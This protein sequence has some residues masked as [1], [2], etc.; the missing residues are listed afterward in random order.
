MFI[1]IVVVFS[2]FSDEKSPTDFYVHCGD[3]IAVGKIQGDFNAPTSENSMIYHFKIMINYG[4]NMVLI[5]K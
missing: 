2:Y 4:Y 3:F 5:N 1:N